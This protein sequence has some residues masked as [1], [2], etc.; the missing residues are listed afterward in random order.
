[1]SP[2]GHLFCFGFGYT[3]SRLAARLSA[4]GWTISGT[5]RRPQ[6]TP[7]VTLYPF[8]VDRPLADPAR[9]LAG[10]T[11]V[12]HSIPPSEAGDPVLLAHA[13]DLARI[14]GIR[15][16]GYLSTTG[17]YGD[18]HGE[19]V[20]EDS[21]A[22][23]VN[24]RSRRRL[25][26][27]TAWQHFGHDHDMRV[28]VFRLAGIYGPGRSAID[29]V[30]QGIARRIDKPGQVFS[31]IHV[32]DTVQVI[33]KAIARELPGAIYNVCDDEPSAQP[34]VIAYA[35]ELLG[36]APPPLESFDTATLR[37][38]TRSFYGASRR[39]ANHRIKKALGVELAY[40]TFRDGLRSCL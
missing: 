14:A 1:M 5:R 34:D 6:P 24:D 40:P 20:D 2:P 23:P 26:A 30:R 39:V 15:W 18:H 9:S 27:E 21:V 33:T 36:V 37:E 12:L 10:V 22:I 8:D 32:D 3:A 11:H 7:G 17:V 29:R 13:D 38:T 19:L 35:A 25:A 4:S 31:R 28:D 16:L